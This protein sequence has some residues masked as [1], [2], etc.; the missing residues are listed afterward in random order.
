MSH[1]LPD[2]PAEPAA[3]RSVDCLAPKFREAIALV[4]ADLVHVGYVAELEET[5]R[6]D[7]RQAWLWGFGRD[8]DDGRGIVTNAATGEHSWHRYGLAVDFSANSGTS[9]WRMLGQFCIAHELQWGGAWPRFTDRPHV[10]WGPPM[11]QSP[12]SRAAELFASG[13]LEAV[14]REVGAL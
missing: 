8:W 3:N 9:F 14:W 6:S 11:R 7:E 10:Q 2:P 4:R 13:G 1:G 12:S 5:C